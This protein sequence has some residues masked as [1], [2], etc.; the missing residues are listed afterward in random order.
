[1]QVRDG[2]PVHL[3]RINRKRLESG[4]DCRHIGTDGTVDCRDCGCKAGDFIKAASEYLDS[5]S[6]W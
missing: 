4:A 2:R 5:R 6:S 3:A 1:V